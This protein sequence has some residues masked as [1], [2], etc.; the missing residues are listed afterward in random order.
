MIE[1]INGFD[2]IDCG[3][4]FY[5]FE[6]QEF[7]Q[8]F[9]RAVIVLDEKQFNTFEA[10]SKL[11]ALEPLAKATG[12]ISDWK[13]NSQATPSSQPVALCSHDSSMSVG[14]HFDQ[15]QTQAHST[16]G[17]VKLLFCLNE[18]FKN[19]L[20]KLSR[21][22]LAIVC[23]IDQYFFS[24]LT[25]RVIDYPTSSGVLGRVNQKIGLSLYDTRF[26]DKR[27]HRFIWQLKRQR[28]LF[29]IQSML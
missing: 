28:L 7:C 1:F 9:S 15:R 26:I 23:D 2:P 14:D 20:K 19:S 10:G 6:R 18:H 21:H 13:F 27:Q 22:S 8:H 29:F 12:N 16:Q 5:P 25:N 4:D 17:A 24:L 3:I 11:I